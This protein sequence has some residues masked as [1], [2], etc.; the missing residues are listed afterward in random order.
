[1]YITRVTI[2]KRIVE[3][4]NPPINTMANGAISGSGFR[5]MGSNPQIAVIDVSTTGIILLLM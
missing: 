3:L 4:T 1:M 5:A 2:L